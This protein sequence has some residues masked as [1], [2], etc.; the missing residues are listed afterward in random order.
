M[1]STQGPKPE[2]CTSKT[3]KCPFK[4]IVGTLFTT[5]PVRMMRYSIEKDELLGTKQSTFKHDLLG[6]GARNESK[7]SPWMELG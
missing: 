7:I 3:D 1:E 2:T 5:Q 4:H 6:A